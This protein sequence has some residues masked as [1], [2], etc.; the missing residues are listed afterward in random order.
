[1]HQH[2]GLRPEG[3]VQYMGGCRHRAE[4]GGLGVQ[5]G[6][7]GYIALIHQRL[8]SLR[9]A[10]KEFKH[11]PGGTEVFCYQGVFGQYRIVNIIIYNQTRP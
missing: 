2:G 10:V 3:V 6:P 5:G 1:M 7:P 9:V 11:I 8:V 4:E